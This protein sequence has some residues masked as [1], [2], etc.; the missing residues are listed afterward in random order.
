MD[1]I[2]EYGLRK[3]DIVGIRDENNTAVLCGKQ[4]FEYF[5]CAT[6]ARD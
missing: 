4:G 3:E 5:P 1:V 2:R 6:L